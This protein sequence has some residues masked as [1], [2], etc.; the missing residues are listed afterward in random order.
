MCTALGLIAACRSHSMVAA[1]PLYQVHTAAGDVGVEPRVA[2]GAP[3]AGLDVTCSTARRLK[4]DAVVVSCNG[5][6]GGAIGS[7]DHSGTRIPRFP[8]LRNGSACLRNLLTS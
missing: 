7:I 8:Y 2:V 3:L 6:C 4:L 1:A 5:A